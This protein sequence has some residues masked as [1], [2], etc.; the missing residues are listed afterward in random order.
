MV[1]SVDVQEA[2]IGWWPR[3]CR[4]RN[5]HDRKVI[6][7]KAFDDLND[8]GRLPESWTSRTSVRKWFNNNKDGILAEAEAMSADECDHEVAHEEEPPSSPAPLPAADEDIYGSSFWTF[9]DDFRSRSD[10]EF[11]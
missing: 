6:T 9:P 7:Q 1:V 11:P 5:A 4:E 10:S 8:S 3:Y 2:L